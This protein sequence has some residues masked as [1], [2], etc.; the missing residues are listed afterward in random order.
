MAWMLTYDGETKTFAAWGLSGLEFALLNYDVSVATFAHAA[1]YDGEA[2]FAFN[3]PATIKLGETIVFQGW[4]GETTRVRD[5]VR[6]RLGYVLNDVWWKLKRLPFQQGW[7]AGTVGAATLF[8]NSSGAPM[9]LGEQLEEV[10]AFAAA[11]GVAVQ[12]G[13][14]AGLTGTPVPIDMRDANCA[15]VLE[16]CRKWS[17]DLAA[18]VDH[19]TTPVTLSFVR[20]ADAEVLTWA[21][22][23]VFGK[24]QLRALQETQVSQAVFRYLLTNTVDGVVSTAIVNDVYP[25]GSNGCA[26]GAVVQTFDLAGYTVTNQSQDLY[27]QNITADSIAWWSSANK[28]PWLLDASGEG[29]TIE[30]GERLMTNVLGELVADTTGSVNEV[31]PGGAIP[32]WV[33]GESRPIVVRATAKN[34]W[35]G[36][37]FFDE[38]KLETTVQATNLAGGTYT[39]APEFTGGDSVP[40]GLAE[41]YYNATHPLHYAGTLSRAFEE[42]PLPMPQPGM[43]LNLTGGEAAARGWTTMKAIIQGVTVDVQRGRVSLTVGAPEHLGPQDLVEMNRTRGGL[44]E[45]KRLL[46]RLG[47]G[48][49]LTIAGNKGTA[50]NN[51]A[52]RPQTGTRGP[53][54]V[55]RVANGSFRITPGTV[56]GERVKKNTVSGDDIETDPAFI[57]ELSDGKIYLGV[58]WEV[59]FSHGFLTMDVST[60]PVAFVAKTSGTPPSDGTEG[61]FSRILATVVD[62]EITYD[63]SIGANI[64]AFIFDANTEAG[65]EAT[66]GAMRV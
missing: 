45:S 56:N 66:W 50:N 62:G 64:T 51:N 24:I 21:T 18:K 30:D 16:A 15:A 26:D 34:F 36:E 20:R 63:G 39:K 4:F 47:G 42:I 6:E 59:V 11:H 57:L 19:T 49:S 53:L 29:F 10:V 2:L 17:P 14:A 65:G 38:Y 43:V 31:L 61:K 23:A 8:A 7:A 22:E 1:D 55:V 33:T 27:V 28:L 44:N 25:P 60:P 41:Q 54:S 52:T 9:T 48:S 35:L 32:A 58:K 12:F 3:E 13:T 37:T 40:A 5:G 46:A